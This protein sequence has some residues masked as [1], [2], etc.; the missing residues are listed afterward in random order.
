MNFVDALNE[1]DL[2]NILGHHIKKGTLYYPGNDDVSIIKD[3]YLLN[4]LAQLTYLN[5]WIIDVNNYDNGDVATIDGNISCLLDRNMAYKIG[6][7][8]S[9]K[10]ISVVIHD[11]KFYNCVL[12][13]NGWFT[14]VKNNEL[15]LYNGLK[16]PNSLFL[17]NYGSC[18]PDIKGIFND[19]IL[20]EYLLKNYVEVDIFRTKSNKINFIEEIRNIL[21]DV[22]L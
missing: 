14:K 16:S 19:K 7:E 12:Y 18:I 9:K 17:W 22:F 1:N 11:D 10:G 3:K 5:F 20:E 21:Y 2:F 8:L 13:K 4:M 15:I 6:D